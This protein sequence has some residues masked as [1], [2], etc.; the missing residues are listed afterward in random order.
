M[1]KVHNIIWYFKG[2]FKC[3]VTLFSGKLDPHPPPRNANNVEYYT[4]V[5]LFFGK[6]DTPPPPPTALRNTWMAPKCNILVTRAKSQYIKQKVWMAVSPK[7][8]RVATYNFACLLSTTQSHFWG[9][10]GYGHMW[11]F[12]NNWLRTFHNIVK[13][14]KRAYRNNLFC[15]KEYS[16]LHKYVNTIL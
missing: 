5:T 15:M 11:T 6:L 8:M 2:P 16:A 14:P 4:F 9:N 3:Y 10:I 12:K 13:W 1:F 7:V